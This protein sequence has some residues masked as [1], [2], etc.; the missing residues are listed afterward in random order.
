[1]FSYFL[2]PR[3]GLWISR[4]A[5]NHGSCVQQYL[6]SAFLL[7]SPVRLMLRFNSCS[8]LFFSFFFFFFNSLPN[9]VAEPGHLSTAVWHLNGICWV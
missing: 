4:C 5:C 3:R 8:K 1:M 2:Q 9:Q 7:S 6:G